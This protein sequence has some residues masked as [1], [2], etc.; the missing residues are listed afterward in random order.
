MLKLVP[1][2]YN[3]ASTLGNY[4]YGVQRSKIQ[5]LQ[6]IFPYPINPAAIKSGFELK[7]QDGNVVDI[8]VDV[9]PLNAADTSDSTEGRSTQVR[10]SFAPAWRDY[11]SKKDGT[12]TLS[13]N[14]S[15]VQVNG[16]ILKSSVLTETFKR[17]FGDINGDGMVTLADRFNPGVCPLT[18]FTCQPMDFNDDG[19]VDVID[20]REYD[21]RLTR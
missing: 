9:T 3:A 5:F 4:Y 19:V 2:D 6:I 7:N 12:Y 13:F 16:L 15:S 14:L 8:M 20:G 18:N 21:K 10:I 1:L 11:S 17:L